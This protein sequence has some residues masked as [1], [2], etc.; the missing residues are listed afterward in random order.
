MSE[1]V[2]LLVQGDIAAIALNPVFI[3]DIFFD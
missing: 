3:T 2:R 1:A